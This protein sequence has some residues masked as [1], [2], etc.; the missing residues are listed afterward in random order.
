MTT[1]WRGPC[2]Q[3]GKHR[4]PADMVGDVVE[5]WDAFTEWVRALH[6]AERYPKLRELAA[7][8][9]VAGF[10]QLGLELA[11]ALD[12]SGRLPADVRAAAQALGEAIL[13]RK[14]QWAAPHVQAK[15]SWPPPD[16]AVLVL[17]PPQQ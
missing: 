4:E 12:A 7:A 11:D 13:W 6:P 14:V 5:Y 15:A 1:N 9:R 10:N 17:F 16:P 8:G 3:M 2:W